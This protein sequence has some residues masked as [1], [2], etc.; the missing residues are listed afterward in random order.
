M[1]TTRPIS[2]NIRVKTI[3]AQ[4]QTS[5]Q[6]LTAMN[7]SKIALKSNEMSELRETEIEQEREKEMAK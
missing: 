5:W 4:L 6:P 3:A 7:T 1:R 2:P